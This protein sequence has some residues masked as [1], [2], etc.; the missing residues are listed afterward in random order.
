MT[1]EGDWLH[2]LEGSDEATGELGTES[3]G[4]IP[5]DPTARTG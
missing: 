3:S 4:S 5:S 2:L 1:V